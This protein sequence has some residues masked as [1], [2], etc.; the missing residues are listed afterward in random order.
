MINK[1]LATLPSTNFRIF[2]TMFFVACTTARYILSGAAIGGWHFDQWQPAG[3]WL[4]FLAALAGLDLAQFHVKR[5][6]YIEAPPNGP[7]IEDA[8]AKP[9][10]E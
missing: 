3:E 1:F 10:E 7:D 2:V 9:K 6:S 8:K 4:L 5:Q